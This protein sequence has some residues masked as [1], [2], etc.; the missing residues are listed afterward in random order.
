ME[1]G[2]MLSINPDA[3]AAEGFDDIRFGVLAAQKGGLTPASN[4][5]SLGL[6]AFEEYIQVRKK[7]KG[8]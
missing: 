6:K 1:M 5:S 4:L 3:H 7:L 2:V 8:I